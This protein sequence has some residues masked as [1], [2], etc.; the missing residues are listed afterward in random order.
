MPPDWRELGEDDC[1]G[2]PDCASWIPL[3]ADFTQDGATVTGT[4]TSTF[5]APPNHEWTVQSGTISVDGTLTLTSDE[6]G[7]GLRDGAVEIRARLVFWESRADSPGVMTG[8][9]AVQYSSDA[10]TGNAVVEG[11]LEADNIL[12]ECSGWRRPGRGSAGLGASRGFLLRRGSGGVEGS[13]LRCR[14]AWRSR[15]R[16]TVSAEP[17]LDGDAGDVD[18]SPTRRARRGG[19]GGSGPAQLALAILAGG[20]R[21][22]AGRAVL[23]G[24]QLER[25]R[26][27]RGGAPRAGHW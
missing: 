16:C 22:G 2:L 26:A 17:G 10:L 19:N 23:P 3:S 14:P 7:F 27:D 4:V 11:C 25:H 13:G 15:T 18:T 12:R 5:A 6:T 21:R 1:D 20:H 8:R 24:V 9:A